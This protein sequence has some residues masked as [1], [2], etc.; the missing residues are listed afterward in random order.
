MA[1]VRS[2]LGALAVLLACLARLSWAAVG[3]SDDPNVKAILVSS[4]SHPPLIS[5]F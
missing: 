4:S 2:R 3:F 1:L 5:R